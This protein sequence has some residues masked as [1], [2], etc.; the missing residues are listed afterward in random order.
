MSDFGA[1]LRNARERR[2]ISLR[3]I[4]TKTKVSIAALESLERNDVSR[5]PGGIFARALVR[6]YAA[7]VGLDPDA[8]VREFTNRFD[9]DPPPSLETSG[10]PLDGDR[11]ETARHRATVLV[12]ILLAT[13]VL[14]A[15]LLLLTLSKA[16]DD[17][18]N[19]PAPDRRAPPPVDTSAHDLAPRL[20]AAKRLL[21]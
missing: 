17:Q 5:L 6:S 14:A 16:P 8:T 2:G 21:S 20:A 4:E 19:R 3:Q 11:L 10:A 1:K 13:L 12:T 18:S 15:I 7:E 9:L